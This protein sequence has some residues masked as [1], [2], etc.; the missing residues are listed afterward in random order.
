MG[1]PVKP[2][3]YQFLIILVIITAITTSIYAE[4]R[5][6]L[7]ISIENSETHVQTQ[8]V[9][10]FAQELRMRLQN[11]IE[12]E[13]YHSARLYRDSQVVGALVRGDVEMAVPG[14]WQL[15]KYIPETD[16]FLLPDFYGASSAEMDRVLG[17]PV[18]QEIIRRIESKLNVVIPGVWM[19]LGPAHLFTTHKAIRKISD[20]NGLRIRV[21][22]GNVNKMRVEALGAEAV[23]ISWPDLPPRI[24]DGYVDGVLTTFESIRS[25]EMWKYGLQ[26][27]YTDSEYFPQ[28]IPMVSLSFW[29]VLT[30]EQQQIFREVWNNAADEQK[31]AA[32]EAQWEARK[33][34]EANGM[35]IFSPAYNE[36]RTTRLL[37]QGEREN[38]IQSLSLDPS[39]LAL[40]KR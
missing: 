7:R 34:A 26:Y 21:A 5:P 24:K 30:P 10:N 13:V 23:I 39:F 19:D 33:I 6:R 2:G 18:G 35:Q 20:I 15:G 8:A 22:G 1:V 31:R 27:A 12:V 28:Y 25:A 3:I 11:S 38:M 14:T 32:A 37:L 40:D 29:Q 36:I 16:Y 4:P 9:M 17:E